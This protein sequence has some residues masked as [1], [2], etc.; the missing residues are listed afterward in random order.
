VYGD[1]DTF[2][3]DSN[4]TIREFK[5]PYSR[6]RLVQECIVH[7]GSLVLKEALQ[8]VLEETGFYD[9]T[10][11]TCEDYDL[12][13]RISEKYI[14]AHVPKSLTKVRVTGDNSSFVVNQ[15]TWRKNW[16]RVMEKMQSRTQ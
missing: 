1:Y 16:L 4:R 7:S 6:K 12:W 9:K 13:M 14:I 5:E 11:R 10:M 15:E 3:V 2:H 8:S